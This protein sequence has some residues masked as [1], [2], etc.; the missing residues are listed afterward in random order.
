MLKGSFS[1][2]PAPVQRAFRLSFSVIRRDRFPVVRRK[3]PQCVYLGARP[4][5]VVRREALLYSKNEALL[6]SQT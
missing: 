3:V 1:P 2:P 5:C 4:S 6:Y